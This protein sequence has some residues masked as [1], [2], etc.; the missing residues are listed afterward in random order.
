MKFFA[1]RAKKLTGELLLFD[2]GE[3]G[4]YLA[5]PGVSENKKVGQERFL[6][7]RLHKL[8]VTQYIMSDSKFGRNFRF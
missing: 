1:Y 8:Q 4:V 7:N 3:L 5:K 2:E 6:Q